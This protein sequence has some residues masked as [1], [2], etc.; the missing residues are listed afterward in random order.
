MLAVLSIGT[1]IGLFAGRG[2]GDDSGDGGDAD[3]A[4]A[5][6]PPPVLRDD[7]PGLAA[8][9]PERLFADTVWDALAASPEELVPEAARLLA[10]AEPEERAFGGVLA[11][12]GNVLEG[13][14]LE[15]VASDPEPRLRNRFTA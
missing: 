1:G 13:E 2:S 5:V 8:L 4:V 3:E 11:F 7:D 15:G 14:L 10:S 12:F 6:A 9:E